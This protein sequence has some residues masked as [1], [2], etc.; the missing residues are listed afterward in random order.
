MFELALARRELPGHRVERLD[1][2]AELVAR[3]RLDP[4]IE[5]AGADLAGTRGEPLHR[6]RDALG[7][8]QAGPRRA[9][10]NHQRHHDEQRQ[11]HA[12]DRTAQREQLAAVLVRLDDLARVLS[13]T[14]PTGSRSRAP[15]PRRGRSASRTAAPPRTSSPP[16]SSGSGGVRLAA[17][18]SRRRDAR[19]S[20]EAR[21]GPR[22]RPG[23]STAT[24]GTTSARCPAFDRDRYTS[25]SPTRPCAT[26]GLD[27]RARTVSRS[28]DSTA[29][30]G[31]S[32]AIRAA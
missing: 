17:R 12:P 20:A 26:S 5:M 25:T 27:A 24:S 2:R 30:T 15:R 11:V 10:Q 4:V 22:G 7:Q 16:P 29:A 13:P 21:T 18:R 23:D 3:L 19:W 28:P 31:I 14:R 6:T 8:I 9:D 1:E 32:R